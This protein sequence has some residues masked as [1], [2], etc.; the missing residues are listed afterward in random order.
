MLVNINERVTIENF[1][2]KCIECL[3]TKA[4]LEIME[5]TRDTMKRY[6]QNVKLDES[7]YI[8]LLPYSKCASCAFKGWKC[9]KSCIF[10]SKGAFDRII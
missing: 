10:A 4:Q 2:F 3:C 8:C 9:N 7:L 1:V 5:Q 6:P